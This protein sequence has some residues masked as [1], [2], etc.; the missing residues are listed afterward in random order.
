[1]FWLLIEYVIESKFKRRYTENFALLWGPQWHVKMI[2]YT[3]LS[4]CVHSYK[5]RDEITVFVNIAAIEYLQ[6]TVLYQSL[7]VYV[8]SKKSRHVAMT[9]VITICVI[10]IN[11][12]FVSCAGILKYL[13]PC[14]RHRSR[15]LSAESSRSRQENITL[16]NCKEV[17]KS[18]NV[19]I[20]YV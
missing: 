16:E 12:I 14:I 3:F 9:Y 17:S 2:V 8:F 19:E 11:N 4:L 13:V 15:S 20:L 6:C 1:M 18:G 10:W 5:A 7:S